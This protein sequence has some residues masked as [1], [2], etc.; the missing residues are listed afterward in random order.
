MS[1]VVVCQLCPTVA[2]QIV[3]WCCVHTD[4]MIHRVVVNGHHPYLSVSSR[5][6]A[7][8]QVLMQYH[9]RGLCAS[10]CEYSASNNILH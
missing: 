9:T 5:S 1:T 4:V 8:I 7:L 10:E 3:F 6:G 2:S